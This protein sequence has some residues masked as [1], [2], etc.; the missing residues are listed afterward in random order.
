V[1]GKLWKGKVGNEESVCRMYL[2]VE[3]AVVTANTAGLVIPRRMK[4][5]E[6]WNVYVERVLALVAGRAR[7][8][9]DLVDSASGGSLAASKVWEMAFHRRQKSRQ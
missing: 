5:H 2:I 4:W 3:Q 7:A 8:A 1:E 6:A 9:A